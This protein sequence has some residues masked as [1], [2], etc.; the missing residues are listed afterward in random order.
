MDS[1]P[2][3]PRRFCDQ[4]RR[5]DA[6]LDQRPLGLDLA[7]RGQPVAGRGRHGAAPI[8]RLFPSAQLVGRDQ[9]PR[10][11]SRAGR[12]TEIWARALR[13]VPD[14]QIPRD[15][16][17]DRGVSPSRTIPRF[18]E[19]G[20]GGGVRPYLSASII[21]FLNRAASIVQH[22]SVF[23]PASRARFQATALFASCAT[24]SRSTMVMPRVNSL[25]HSISTRWRLHWVP[26]ER[27]RATAMAVGSASERPLSPV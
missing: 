3:D 17:A 26:I 2:A 25:A 19:E 14:E 16:D 11:L 15:G 18:A 20:Q 12:E 7:S 13:S 23:T 6:A 24:L 1:R 21:T 9:M 4:S 8:A 22:T 27:S 10:S 5:F